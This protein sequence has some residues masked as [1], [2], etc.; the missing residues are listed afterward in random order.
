MG[1]RTKARKRALDLLFEAEQRGVNAVTLLDERVAEPVTPAPL[2]DYTADL[3]RGVVAHWSVI[4]ET[5]QTYTDWPMDRM[6]AVDRALL[7][8]A[9]WELAFNDDVPEKVAIAEATHLASE[10][11]TDASPQFMSGL[12]TQV[13]QVKHTLA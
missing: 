2:P 13:A 9:V 6:P 8:L 4:N 10:L 7:R 5:I 3:V 1:A 11:S 12:L